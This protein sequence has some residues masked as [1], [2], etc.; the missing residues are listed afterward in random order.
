MRVARSPS[1]SASMPTVDQVR[2]HP[3]RRRWPRAGLALFSR[4]FSLALAQPLQSRASNASTML[5]AIVFAR[6][7]SQLFVQRADGGPCSSLHPLLQLLVGQ[8]A[9]PQA[10][11]AGA[12]RERRERSLPASASPSPIPSIPC[13][14]RSS[15]AAIRPC[16]SSIWLISPSPSSAF[17]GPRPCESAA[18]PLL[19]ATLSKSRWEKFAPLCKIRPMTGRSTLELWPVACYSA[20]QTGFHIKG[21][22][23][24]GYRRPSHCQSRSLE[25]RPR[26]SAR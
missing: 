11:V 10:P 23:T 1:S 9:R 5:S 25:Q 20:R 18:G 17:L 14:I 7:S 19:H 4:S 26:P 13:P 16:R 6:R 8:A 12:F 3:R 21:C 2:H 22:P 24:R 15:A